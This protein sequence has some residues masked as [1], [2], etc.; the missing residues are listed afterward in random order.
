[1]TLTM[2]DA[3]KAGVIKRPIPAVCPW[4]GEN[5]PL[6]SLIA[7]RFIVGCENEDCHAQPQVSGNTP[8]QAWKHWNA[9]NV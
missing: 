4:C 9:R 7:G 6:A 5:P 8:E 2:L 3:I 1:M